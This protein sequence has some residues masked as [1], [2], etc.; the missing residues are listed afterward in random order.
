MEQRDTVFIIWHRSNIE[1]AT[2]PNLSIKLGDF[3]M[4]LCGFNCGGAPLASER[5]AAA[6]RL[7]IEACIDAF[8]V[9]RSMFESNFLVDGS[10][11]SYRML[12]NA[13]KR[14]TS[15]FGRRLELALPSCR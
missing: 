3:G 1:L 6:W 11:C 4:S 2:C 9:E 8:G 5:L 13:F 10:T 7:Y 15:G 14:I 12:W